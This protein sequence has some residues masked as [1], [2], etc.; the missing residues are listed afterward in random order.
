MA[1]QN[2]NN[3]LT[4]VDS[5]KK[6]MEAPSVQE[7]FKNAIADNSGPFIASIIELYSGDT[8]LQN[9]DPKLVI[10]E[11]LKA[12]I[13]K[14]P[15]NKSLGFAYIVPYNNQPQ[16]QI[17]YKGLIQLAMRSAFYKTIHADVVYEG[18]FRSR[19]KLKGTFDVA[20]QKTSDE[21]IGYFAYFELLNGF[22][23]TLYMTKDRVKQHAA[24]YSKSFKLPN[25]PWTKEFDAMAIKTVIR[26]LLSHYGMLS[27]EMVD[28]MDH[29]Q[30]QDISDKVN[31]E[32]NQKANQ[33][34]VDLEFTNIPATS[35]PAETENQGNTKPPF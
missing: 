16:F 14:L 31:N 2:S 4:K 20:G 35:T 26:N 33:E 18:E 6:M 30:D 24:K 17:G 12:A 27:I 23:K 21:V 3:Q 25:G 19:D 8:Y 28:A 32:I 1:T 34:T 15:I 22:S 5:L 13:L 10:M 9:C 7:Q 29:D 11:A